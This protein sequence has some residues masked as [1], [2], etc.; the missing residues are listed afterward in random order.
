MKFEQNL[1]RPYHPI[2]LLCLV[3]K[4]NISAWSFTYQ[5]NIF[6]HTAA[7]ASLLLWRLTHTVFT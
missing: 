7:V 3:S 2:R 5:R 1:F 6:T 4:P